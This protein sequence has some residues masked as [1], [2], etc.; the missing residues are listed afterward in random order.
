MPLVPPVTT[1]TRSVMSCRARS[2]SLSIARFLARQRQLD[3]H[4]RAPARLAVDRHGAAVGGDDGIDDGQ[5]EPA[6]A[7]VPR[8]G[9]VGAEEALEGPGDD[10][11]WH[12]GAAVGDLDPGP[13]VDG[14]R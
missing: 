13:P 12:P 3:G 11:G 14:L 9:R 10:L 6:A 1:T 4:G 5:A 8:P 7:A 2:A